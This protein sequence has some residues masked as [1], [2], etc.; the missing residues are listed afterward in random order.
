MSA[1]SARGRVLV[2]GQLGGMVVVTLVPSKEARGSGCVVEQCAWQLLSLRYE[3]LP[4]A[5]A[6]GSLA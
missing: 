1:I 2:P 5:E 4:C 6:H 3:K